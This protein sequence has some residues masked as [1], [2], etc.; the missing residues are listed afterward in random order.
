MTCDLNERGDSAPTPLSSE[1]AVAQIAR[2]WQLRLTERLAPLGLTAAQ[3]R[4]LRAVASRT[5]GMGQRELAAQIGVE[6]PGVVRL[7]DMLEAAGLVTRRVGPTDRRSRIVQATPLAQPVIKEALRINH[8]LDHELFEGVPRE[9]LD[10]CG[11]VLRRLLYKLQSLRP[12]D[13]GRQ[14]EA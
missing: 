5:D 8:E 10:T 2:G 3:W 12:L 7:V 14:Q 9:D 6:E 13:N 1:M 4:A 11:W